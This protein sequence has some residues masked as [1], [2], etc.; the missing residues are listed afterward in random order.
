MRSPLLIT[1]L[2]STLVVLAVTH[3]SALTFFL[4]W[5]YW[6]LDIV[7][8]ILGG[9]SVALGVIILQ[10][11]LVRVPKR[12]FTFLPVVVAVFIIGLFWEW[13]EIAFDISVLDPSDFVSD[14]ITDLVMD[15]IGG[16]I[17]YFVGNHM[18]TL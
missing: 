15:M 12:Y 6:W 13:Y 11:F 8:H 7:I 17:G 16:T 1:L 4:Y 18:K 3:I 14:T 2:L 10:S 5:K 9:I